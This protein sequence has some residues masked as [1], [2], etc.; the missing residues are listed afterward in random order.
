MIKFV[1]GSFH[2]ADLRFG[3]SAGT[4]CACCGLVS[5]SFTLVK[6]ESRKMV[7]Y[8]LVY[9][10]QTFVTVFQSRTI[11]TGILLA[12]SFSG[13]YLYRLWIDWYWLIALHTEKVFLYCVIIC[14]LNNILLNCGG[15]LD[16]PTFSWTLNN[17][18]WPA[19]KILSICGG[20]VAVSYT[21]LTLP[22]K[23]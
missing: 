22:T 23:A 20:Y 6:R 13:W 16:T 17:L 21:H 19:R 11:S 14:A 7:K 15:V 8:W 9:S 18:L 1:Q 3:N 5:V 4:Q 10:F 2:Q 12:F